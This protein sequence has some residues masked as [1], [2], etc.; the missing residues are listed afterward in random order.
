MVGWKEH[1][2]GRAR[3]ATNQAAQ[4]RGSHCAGTVGTLSWRVEA[5]E[6]LLKN[7]SFRKKKALWQREEV[8]WVGDKLCLEKI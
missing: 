6:A 3:C 7:E 1:H 5:E 8:L 4:E 2:V